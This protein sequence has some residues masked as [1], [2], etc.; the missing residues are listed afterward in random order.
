MNCISF[1]FKNWDVQMYKQLL[2]IPQEMWAEKSLCWPLSWVE[3]YPVRV[4]WLYSSLNLQAPERLCP[5]RVE[6]VLC[7]MRAGSA[8]LVSQVPCQCELAHL[9]LRPEVT[10]GS[11]PGPLPH[12]FFLPSFD[13]WFTDISLPLAIWQ[14]G[15]LLP[16]LCL[17]LGRLW[18]LFGSALHLSCEQCCGASRYTV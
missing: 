14:S 17:P 1:L 8:L 7:P 10:A 12:L 11:L 4:L 9:V 13:V 2:L 18:S 15:F 6:Y 5:L 16:P 3:L